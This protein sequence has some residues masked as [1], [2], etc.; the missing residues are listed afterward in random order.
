MA[1]DRT[2]GAHPRAVPR[3]RRLEAIL[4][5]AADRRR[6]ANLTEE[7]AW[8]R[9]RAAEMQRLLDAFQAA[10]FADVVAA[11][12]AERAEELYAEEEG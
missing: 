6:A 3:A 1:V 12:V 5:R 11:G 4:D 10:N 2:R 8:L 7:N 9:E